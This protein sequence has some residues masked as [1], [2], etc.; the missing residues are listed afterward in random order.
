MMEKAHVVAVSVE[1][2]LVPKHWLPTA[3][4]DSW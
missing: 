1:Y 3:S 2:R 4:E